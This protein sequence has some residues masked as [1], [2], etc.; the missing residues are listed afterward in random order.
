M[1]LR[2]ILEPLIAIRFGGIGGYYFWKSIFKGRL[3]KYLW[4]RW[5]FKLMR[6]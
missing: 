6:R 4:N 5:L 1:K 2:H 3:H